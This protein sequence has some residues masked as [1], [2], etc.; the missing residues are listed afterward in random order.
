V[1]VHEYQTDLPPPFPAWFGSPASF[2]APTFVP[3]ALP[4]VPDRAVAATKA[5]FAGADGLGDTTVQLR[6]AGVPSTFPAPSVARTSKACVP[7]T[8]AEYVLGDVHAAKAPASTRHSNVDPVS[9]DVNSNVA[10]VE[11]TEPDGPLVIVVSGGV[12]SAGGETVHV[13]EAGVESVFP[14]ASFARTSKV[15]EPAAS[16]E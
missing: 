13:R 11:V 6:D 4:L 12:V 9:V 16:A 14:A 3:V 5:S 2:V 7:S 15:C 8:S 10:V 1:A